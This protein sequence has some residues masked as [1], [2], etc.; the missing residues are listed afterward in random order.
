VERLQGQELLGRRLGRERLCALPCRLHRHGQPADLQQVWHP[1]HPR[2]SKQQPASAHPRLSKQHP[3]SAQPWHGE[4]QRCCPPP[5]GCP[6]DS[7]PPPTRTARFNS[8]EAQTQRS[9][10]PHW[11][12]ARNNSQLLTWRPS[13]AHLGHTDPHLKPAFPWARP[14]PAQAGEHCR[15]IQYPYFK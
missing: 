12:L 14:S 11:C 10:Q 9:W 1:A 8:T 6:L 15:P 4:G 5:Q 2:L 3:G 7:E 13:F